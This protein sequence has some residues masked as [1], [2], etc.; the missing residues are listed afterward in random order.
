MAMTD[1]LSVI[2][3]LRGNSQYANQFKQL[4]NVNIN[5]SLDVQRAYR[6]LAQAISAFE[7]SEVFNKF[8]S[9]FDYSLAGATKL[10]AIE[11]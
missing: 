1:E 2:E 6:S 7:T 11:Q 3:R 10:S 9:K 5:D 8:N 4:Y